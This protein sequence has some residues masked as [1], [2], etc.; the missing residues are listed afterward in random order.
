MKRTAIGVLWREMLVIHERKNFVHEAFICKN[1]IQ[2][3]IWEFSCNFRSNFGNIESG[4]FVA[5]LLLKN[6]TI[7]EC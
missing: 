2:N 3:L 4:D 7:H 5:I 6:E 1:H